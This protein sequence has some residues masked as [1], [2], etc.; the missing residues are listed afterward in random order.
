MRT[1]GALAML[2]SAACLAATVDEETDQATD[3]P[4]IT[5][6]EIL[7]NPLGD[8]DYTETSRCLSSGKYRQIDV[9]TNQILVF[10]GRGDDVWL[11]ILRTRCL[12]LEPDMIPTIE[13][14][15]MRVC[16]RDQFRGTSRFR[17]QGE[18]MPCTLGEFH[19]TRPANIAAIRDAL[20]A[21]HR[22]KTVE[23]TVRAAERE[24]EAEADPQ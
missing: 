20:E 8:D 22:T 9:M 17:D 1:R 6:E 2:L 13:R 4:E 24:S 16:S 19:R 5:A 18:S 15:G 10:R 14:R 23:K 11:N 12:G 21:N 7:A 3:T